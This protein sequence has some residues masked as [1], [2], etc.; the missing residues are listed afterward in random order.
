MNKQKILIVEDE[1]DIRELIHF[2]LYRNK[3]DVIEAVNGEEG[4]AKAIEEEPDLIILD[5]MM[6]IFNGLEVC[7][8]V[9]AIGKL[10]KTK[11][12][13]LSANGEESDIIKGLE[14]GGDDYIAKPFS[15]NILVARVKSVLRR[16]EK[17]VH[18][19]AIYGI[20]INEDK[21]L[22]QIDGESVNLSVT[23]FQVLS[24]FVK[25][26]GHVYT[27]AQIVDLIRGHNHAVTDRSV[28]TQVVG[29]RKKLKEKGKLIETVWGVGYR[30]KDQA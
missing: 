29:L 10:D 16:N 27:R 1:A 19:Q 2:H 25:K 9:R 3:F 5:I 23:E 22:V 26:P 7:Q 14:L 17:V 12:I 18:N 24:L 8:K 13:F 6:P 28:D 30:F 15:P 20:V 4:I 21:R 11:I